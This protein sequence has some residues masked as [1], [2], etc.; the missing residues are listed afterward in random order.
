[1]TVDGR[2][3]PY[4]GQSR[5]QFYHR[6]AVLLF[7]VGLAIRAYYYFSNPPIWYDEAWLL[8]NLLDKNYQD[9]LGPLN[10]ACNGPPL[11]LWL[12]R[13]AFLC[14]GDH[15]LAWRLPGFVAGLA[16]LVL[17][18]YVARRLLP[19]V[20]LPWAVGLYALSDRLLW[21]TVEVRPYAVDV[22]I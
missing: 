4:L 13:T 9:L 19:P 1:M 6:V 15:P 7:C 20:G 16:G 2:V 12:E 8:S 10:H 21:H 17:F 5:D 14:L 3:E 11:F 22:C 18:F